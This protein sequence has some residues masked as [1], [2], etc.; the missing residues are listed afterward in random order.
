MTGQLGTWGNK[1]PDL[2]LLPAHRALTRVSH[3]PKASRSQR[4]R[5]PIEATDTSYP[6]GTE[7]VGKR[8]ES[9]PGMANGTDPA[10]YSKSLLTSVTT[11][12]PAAAGKTQF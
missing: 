4:T 10:H 3:W 12:M 8:I 11:S 1:H 2:I 7:Q 9:R 5:E 6:A